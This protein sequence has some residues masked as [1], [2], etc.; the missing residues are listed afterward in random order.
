MQS[1]HVHQRDDRRRRVLAEDRT[2]E[3][4]EAV[5]PAAARASKRTADAYADGARQEHQRRVTDLVPHN[6]LS[7]GLLFLCGVITIVAL[8]RPGTSVLRGALSW[9]VERGCRGS[10][11]R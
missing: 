7:I 1:F 5:K 11:V 8:W 6:Y 9:S 4:P 2:A 3:T 10:G